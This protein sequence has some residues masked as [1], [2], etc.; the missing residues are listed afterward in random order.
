MNECPY[1]KKS[2]DIRGECTHPVGDGVCGVSFGFRKERQCSV[3]K[4]RLN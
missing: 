4:K 1:Y 2:R 3:F